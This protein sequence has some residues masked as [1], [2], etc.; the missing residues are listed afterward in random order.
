M[1][2]D[3]DDG[4]EC[5][6]PLFLKWIGEWYDEA[7][8]RNAKTQY[9]LRKAHQ[10][11]KLY[12]LPIDNPKD[13]VQLQGIGQGIAGRLE[14][15][16]AQ[17]RKENNIPEPASAADANET[18]GAAQPED[19]NATAAAAAAKRQ[20]S[21]L[22]VPKYRSGPFALI[23]GLFKAYCLYGPDYYIPK[24]QLVPLCVQYT[25]TP[26]HVS[27]GSG[28]H[29]RPGGR[30]GAHGGASG[31]GG[32]GNGG[33]G[34]GFSAHTA[35]S[36]M[37]TLEAKFLVDR[38][39]G[40]RFCLTDEGLEIAA[41]VVDVLRARN[42]LPAEDERVFAG[43]TMPLPDQAEQ[44]PTA[45]SLT[46]DVLVSERSDAWA[47]GF[48]SQSASEGSAVQGDGR[49]VAMRLPPPL[50]GSTLGNAARSS[51]YLVST[52]GANPR[53][54]HRFLRSE[55]AASARSSSPSRAF[56][57]NS[58]PSDAVDI[59]LDSLIHYLPG[60]YDIILIVDNREVHS[61]SD[62]NLISKEL[63]DQQVAIEIRPLTVGD[64][65]WIAR[66][67][68]TGQCRALP[69]IVLDCV[70]ERKRM[71]DL[72][73]SIKD[74]RYKEQHSRLHGTGFT[75]VL[76]I[77]EGNDP[78]AVSRLGEAAVNSALSRIQVAHGFH[79]KRPS[80]FEATL[81]L[82][83]QTTKVL[84]ESLTH[85]YAVPDHM[86]GQKGYAALKST[87]KARF[88][89]IHLALSFDA[90]DLVSSKSRTLTVG[91]IYLRMLM[92]MKGVSADRALGLGLKYP[93]PGELMDGLLEDGSDA[94]LANVT[95]YK[96]SQRKIG[97]AL[98]KRIKLFWS[99]ESFD[100]LV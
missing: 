42:E 70:V 100:T 23:I 72:C 83:R 65:L 7:C 9:T 59:E 21:R 91:E 62:R 34:G 28:G 84:K 33:S 53:P 93:T 99:A 57:R 85:I 79:L 92:A 66:A 26:F 55:S 50:P 39:S 78:D 11:L 12:P 90:Y 4:A 35:W 25:D 74:G 38:Q 87:I 76:Y 14:K 63:E 29:G 54:V 77:V 17:W 13:T 58:T 36:G 43:F 69:D 56:S 82:L 95:S 73:A 67:K 3:Q 97:P 86:I 71:D 94:V 48:L 32:G 44:L 47:D 51:T 75:N 89:Q 5:A 10:S 8:K 46:D 31:G 64:Y 80:S 98:S 52:G 45:A 40:V 2:G 22:Y 19:A 81:K 24:A 20:A 41:K 18:A 6:N 1:S 37:K 68:P 88:P 16:L 30:G 96:S 27:G 60:E 15:R 49:S 61:V